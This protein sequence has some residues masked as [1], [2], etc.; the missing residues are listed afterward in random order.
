[1][2]SSIIFS[3]GEGDRGLLEVLIV[4]WRGVQ[5]RCGVFS[6]STVKVIKIVCQLLILQSAG[7]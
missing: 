6:K 1:M 3:A 2:S 7:G 4:E 5:R